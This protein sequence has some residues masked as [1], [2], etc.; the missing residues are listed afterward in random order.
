[1]VELAATTSEE[2]DEDKCVDIPK[3]ECCLV[4]LPVTTKDD[5]PLLDRSKHKLKSNFILFA[6]VDAMTTTALPMNE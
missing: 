5:A 2:Y 1:M 4:V 3:N 6:M